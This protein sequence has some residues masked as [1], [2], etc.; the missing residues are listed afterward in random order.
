M[1]NELYD[2][3]VRSGFE[4]EAERIEDMRCRT[5][6]TIREIDD[7]AAWDRILELSV[8]FIC[9]ADLI[10]WLKT[11]IF[12]FFQ[13]TNPIGTYFQIDDSGS[14]VDFHFNARM[15]GKLTRDFIG[16]MNRFFVSLEI[17]AK[18]AYEHYILLID[19]C[20]NED[21]YDSLFLP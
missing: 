12:D 7:E 16:S 18:V 20:S 13:S 5:E 6:D 15:A 9:H 4:T 19:E 11:N 21:D 14:G 1:P 17:P 2:W 3:K 8:E 10:A